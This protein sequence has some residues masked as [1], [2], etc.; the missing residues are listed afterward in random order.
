[1]ERVVSKA[2]NTFEESMEVVKEKRLKQAL[3]A[4][5]FVLIA[6]IIV[7][8]ENL[9]STIL[10]L[11]IIL[12]MMPTHLLIKREKVHLAASY[13]L[14]T[15]GIGL[16]FFIWNGN[17]VR[18]E[19][20]LALPGI[21]LFAAILDE[22]KLFFS[23]LIL[24]VLNIILIGYANKIGWIVSNPAYSTMSS[25]VISAL[26]I[27]GVTLAVWLL[28]NDLTKAAKRLL[29]EA[30]QAEKSK[31]E[32]ERLV[33]FDQLTG[34]PNRS[35]AKKYFEQAELKRTKE[36]PCSAI[37]FVDLD[38]FKS[39][40]D[41]YGHSVGDEFLKKVAAILKKG[42]RAY[43]IVCRQGGDEF[44][45][46]VQEIEDPDSL[47]AIAINVLEKLNS[48]IVINGESL[49]ISCSIGI[50]YSLIDGDDFE[51]LLKKSDMA[52][53][54]AKSSG[55]NAF[56]FYDE[57]VNIQSHESAKLLSDMHTAIKGDN[58]VLY[59]QPKY[60]LSTGKIVGAEALIRWNHP[61]KGIIAPNLF[62][63]L[64]EKSGLIS[65]IG[66]W[67]LFE[68]CRAC[69]RWTLLGRDDLHIAINVSPIQF[70]RD[71]LDM[72]VREALTTT[73]LSANQLEIE[74]TEGT[75]MDNDEVLEQTL[76]N[77]N[78]LGVRF[79]IDDFGTGYSN[80][81]YLKQYPIETLKIDQS[82]VS[83][84]TTN[85]N[86]RTIVEAVIQMAI[87]L[88]LDTVAEGIET[89]EQARLIES[90]GCKYGQGY[91]W[92]RPVTEQDFLKLLDA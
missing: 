19:S 75:L 29:N 24:F 31:E 52:M 62:I 88:E 81:G 42:T 11:L 50:A 40:N 56:S 51:Q 63:P 27:F 86:D 79:S 26:I 65:E 32:I 37:L 12:M 39:I 87:K 41:T 21:L 35:L 43:D 80:L 44:V 54:H 45:I 49:T 20:M 28:E 84:I 38:N 18:D 69:Q 72:L 53:Y 67:V 4:S 1:M 8:D 90:A 30:Q 33:N 14:S 23:L 16:L 82:F 6:A 48:P 22:K 61:I 91:L 15:L 89:K 92:S 9:K 66:R 70:R 25:S 7:F 47:A 34:L 74:I 3:W 73:K 59:Y 60:E 46:V 10:S 71:D 64:A 58:F 17:G 5:V 36:K 13:F 68:A 2:I 78:E 83:N 85:N 57:K 76:S 77:L 55:K